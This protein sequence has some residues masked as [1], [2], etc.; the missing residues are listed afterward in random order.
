[1]MA[2]LEI[3][4]TIGGDATTGSPLDDGHPGTVTDNP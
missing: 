2:T 4:I 1:M 3:E